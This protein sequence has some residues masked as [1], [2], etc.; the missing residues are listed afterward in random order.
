[1]AKRAITDGEKVSLPR[2]KRLLKAGAIPRKF[3]CLLSYLTKPKLRSRTMTRRSPAKRRR[4]SSSCARK[5]EVHTKPGTSGAA[6]C[7]EELALRTDLDS[8]EPTR[9]SDSACR[10]DE[11]TSPFAEV[12]LLKCQLRATKQ[13]LTLCQTKLSKMRVQASKHKMLEESLRKMSTRPKLIFYQCVMKANAKSP[14]AA[15]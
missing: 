4:E 15:R 14:R 6:S 13:L 5:T 8:E 7:D 9:T 11:F 2:D 3:D 1:M 10:T 12:K